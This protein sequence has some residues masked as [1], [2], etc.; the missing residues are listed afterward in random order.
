MED[1]GGGHWVSHMTGTVP[2]KEKGI[3]REELLGSETQVP[4]T[5]VMSPLS[6][7][8][9][10]FFHPCLP[11][12]GKGGSL[13][14]RPAS[15][16]FSPGW[17]FLPG[18]PILPPAVSSA[19]PSLLLDWIRHWDVQWG[20]QIAQAGFIESWLL[21]QGGRRA[22]AGRALTSLTAPEASLWPLLPAQPQYL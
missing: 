22:E 18:I 20:L 8:S 5:I 15:W 12:A 16:D 11:S 19:P 9:P 14:V 17:V 6:S 7:S 21:V 13:G 1:L 3:L 2:G 4:S 10:F